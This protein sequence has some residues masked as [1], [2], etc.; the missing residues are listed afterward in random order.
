MQSEKLEPTWALSTSNHIV[1]P[2]TTELCIQ[3]LFHIAVTDQIASKLVCNF[4]TD[5]LTKG[6]FEVSLHLACH[7]QNNFILVYDILTSD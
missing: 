4:F 5:I 1:P 7:L 3:V 6:D 2:S